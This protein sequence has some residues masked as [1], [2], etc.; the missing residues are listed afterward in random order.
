MSYDLRIYTINSQVFIGLRSISNI[1]INEEGFIL[2]FK[3]H[4]I[5]I[6]KETPIEYE[7][8]PQQISKELPGLKYLIE[9]NL[10]PITNNEKHIKELLKI[11]KIIAK[12]GMGVIENPQTDEIV[13][14]S[15]VKRVLEIE[16]TERFSIIEMSWWFNHDSLLKSNNLKLL[17]EAIEK[18]IPEALPRRYGEYE[19]PREVF[20]DITSFNDYIMGHIKN[21]IVWYPSKPVDYVSLGIPEFI[22]PMRHGYRFG[23]FSISIDAAVLAMPGWTTTMVRL[24]KSISQILNPFYGDVYMLKNHIRSRTVSYSDGKTEQHPIAGWWWNGIPR[25]LGIGLIIGRPILDYVK[26]KNPTFVLDNGCEILLNEQ[27]G[28]IQSKDVEISD[29]ILQPERKVKSKV[30]VYGFSGLYPKIWPFSGPKQ[31]E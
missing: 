1:K 14:P 26:I 24:I 23:Q 5:V 16:K 27:F 17:L 29:D 21:L 4:Q 19:P 6:S 11:A 3:N 2:P 30:I 15:G 8:I 18:Y 20:T 28:E 7:D 9:C 13:L 22:G 12:E 25:K 31:E 10:E